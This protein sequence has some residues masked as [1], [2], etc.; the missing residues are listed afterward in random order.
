MGNIEKMVKQ[1]KEKLRAKEINQ[2]FRETAQMNL[3]ASET[4]SLP[5]LLSIIA[6]GKD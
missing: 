3:L 1:E 2:L 6:E 4:V 5:D